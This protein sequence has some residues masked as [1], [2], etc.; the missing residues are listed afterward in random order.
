MHRD[1]AATT[2][3]RLRLPGK[4]RFVRPT[5]LVRLGEIRQAI[6]GQVTAADTA[7]DGSPVR[8]PAVWKPRHTQYWNELLEPYG[9]EVSED[10]PFWIE[11]F[12]LVYDAGDPEA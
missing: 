3:P 1:D 11:P 9:L 12:E 10:M 6:F 7:V 2:R 5:L 4:R 8:D